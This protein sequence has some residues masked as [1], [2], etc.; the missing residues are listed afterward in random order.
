MARGSGD[1]AAREQTNNRVFIVSGAMAVIGGVL[2]WLS[3]LSWSKDYPQWS[4]F[5]GQLGGLLVATGLVTVAWETFGRRQF[6]REVLSLANLSTDLKNS[7]IVR[8]SDQ[9][10]DDVELW[11]RL[12]RDVKRLDI[13]V[14]YAST[15]RNTHRQR[16]QSAAQT[17]GARIRVFL[18]DPDDD[19][20]M[21][22]LAHRFNMEVDTLRGKVAE[23]KLDFES[24]P[25]AESASL[26]VFLRPGDL[27]YSA[28]RF[29]SNAVVT[30]YS[31]SRERQSSVPMFVVEG[32]TLFR[33]VKNDI[34]AILKQAQDHADRPSVAVIPGNV[35]ESGKGAKR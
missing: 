18:P 12:F 19:L 7:G 29:D 2:M 23:A 25:V 30:L 21:R 10:L 11:A 16:L 28:Y 15:W 27:V 34:D 31:H 1:R 24:L 17:K 33:F 9:Y 26:T 6:T 5:L 32:G 14:A 35:I 22:T 20:T 13:V 3:G 8:I 4:A